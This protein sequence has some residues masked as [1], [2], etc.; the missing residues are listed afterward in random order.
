MVWPIWCVCVRQLKL[1]LARGRGLSALAV[2][3]S[4]GIIAFTMLGGDAQ[5]AA[6]AAGAAG[7]AGAAAAVAAA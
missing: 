2:A 5:A 1:R 6:D 4:L 3:S 7:A